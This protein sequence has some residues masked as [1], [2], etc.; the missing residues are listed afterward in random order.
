MIDKQV[1]NQDFFFSAKFTTADA[2]LYHPFFF[3]ALDPGNFA[4]VAEFPHLMRLYE[5]VREI[6]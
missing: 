5:W 6:A 2:S 4:K 1:A 3:L